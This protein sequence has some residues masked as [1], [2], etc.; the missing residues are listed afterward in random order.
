MKKQLLELAYAVSLTVYSLLSRKIGF[1][2]FI[3]F[4]GRWWAYTRR[5]LFPVAA[6]RVC[7]L[8]YFRHFVP[9]RGELVLDVGGELG[10]EAEQ[11][12]RMV[13]PEG[14]V[15]TFE[16]LP[17]HVARLK[18]IAS[19]WPNI[20]VVE[21][22]C[23]DHT[24]VLEFFPGRTPGSGTAVPSTRGQI[25]QE[26]ADTS[27]DA[28]RVQAQ[29]L[30]EFWNQHISRATIG[31]LKMD[32]EG[33]EYEALNGA[34]EML[35]HTRRVVI[36]AYH[37]RDEVRTAPRVAEMLREAGFSVRVDENSHV[38][39]IRSSTADPYSS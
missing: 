7:A 33:A 5:R 34:K 22:A 32:I 10:R 38:Y 24:T 39:G 36:A 16:C 21:R 19:R 17:V 14:K 20:H 26:L 9:E 28:I 15:F 25:G 6:P 1:C 3:P 30:D 37:I 4:G 2:V 11:F 31:F 35:L 18:S 23:W 13:G 12:A 8:E 27:K 29:T